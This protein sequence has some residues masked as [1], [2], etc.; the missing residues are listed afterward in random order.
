[1]KSSYDSSS[2]RKTT[3]IPGIQPADRVSSAAPVW[4]HRTLGIRASQKQRRV[5]RSF[6]EPHALDCRLMLGRTA[7]VLA[8]GLVTASTEATEPAA[9]APISIRWPIAEMHGIGDE[10]GLRPFRRYANPPP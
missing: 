3:L 4:R 2:T 1:M 10:Q 6:A 7:P 8:V 5:R 9:P